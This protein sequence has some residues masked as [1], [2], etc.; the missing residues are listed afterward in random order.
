M[1]LFNNLLPNPDDIIWPGPYWFFGLMM[2]LYIVYRLFL[3]KKNWTWVVAFIA[4]CTVFELLCDPNGETINRLRYNFVGGMLPFGLGLLY[5]KYMRNLH[6]SAFYLI[7]VISFFGVWYGDNYYFTWLFVPMFICSLVVSFVKIIMSW[8]SKNPELKLGVANKSE[9][10][11]GLSAAMFISH[12]ITRK[13]IIPISKSGD[14]YTGLLLYVITS[15]CVAWLFKEFMK[16][17]PSPKL[18]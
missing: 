1:G 3:Y 8:N 9:W 4:I 17:V 2:Q 15:I 18:K 10:L 11:G 13:I 6:I 14:L 5:A 16:Q 12:P 7:F